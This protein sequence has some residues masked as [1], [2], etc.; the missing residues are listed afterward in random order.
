A[1]PEQRQVFREKVQESRPQRLNDSNHTA[2]LN[3]EQR[4]AVRERL[5]ERGAR[6]LER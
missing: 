5:S 1:S 3:N 6:R 2:R 4:S